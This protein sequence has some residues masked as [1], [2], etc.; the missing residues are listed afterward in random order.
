[1][2]LLSL[3]ILFLLGACSESIGQAKFIYKDPPAQG[4]AAKIGDQVITD[5]ELKSGIEDELYEAERKL[6]DVK[7]NKVRQMMLK[8]FMEKDPKSKG[9]SND[10]YLNKFIA[11]KVKVTD[12]DIE[13]FIKDRNL[14]R[15]EINDMVR[16]KIRE[17]VG[18]EKKRV[19]VDQ[20]MS[21][22]MAKTP[23]EIYIPKPKRPMF[24]V[25]PGTGP[26]VGSADAKVT[27]VEFSDFQCPYCSQAAKTMKLLKDKYKDKIRI[28]FRNFP[29]HFHNQAEGAAVAG[30]CAQEQKPEF[31]WKLHDHMFE[32]QQG[33]LDLQSL[34]AAARKL[35][36]KGEQF[37]QCLDSNKY[38]A[39]VRAD[40]DEGKRVNVKSTPTFFVNGQLMGGA[41][42]PEVFE[43]VIEDILAQK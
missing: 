30:L 34:K 22:Q 42:P 18:N 25:N 2:K 27:I 10:E 11:S 28:V 36:L 17:V 13:K 4:Q 1:M 31:F 40:M 38:L 41:F 23:V 32:N 9:L 15:E 33:G 7:I 20:W 29:L 26:S 43:E 5:A 16:E 3:S 6:Y 8:T 21:Q 19:A 12:G 14:P 24:D 37:D 39:Q 35:G